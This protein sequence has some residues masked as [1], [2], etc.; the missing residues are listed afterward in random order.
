M[1]PKEDPTMLLP[2]FPQALTTRLE[3]IAQKTG[4]TWEECLL[5]AVADFVE[6]WEEYHR[7]IET[8]QEEEVRP[9]LKAVNE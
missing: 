7:T 4:K 8:L 6:G 5:Q 1:C 9:V 2:E 3:A